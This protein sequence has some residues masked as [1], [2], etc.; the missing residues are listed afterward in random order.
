MQSRSTPRLLA[1]SAVA[2]LSGLLSTSPAVAADSHR[3]DNHAA[4][5]QLDH[6]A[7]WQTDAALRT[8]ME[9][10]RD[11][12]ARAIPQVHAGRFDAA[13]YRAL[14]EGVEGQVGYIVQNCKL[15]PEADEVLHAIIARL[16][17]GVE[18]IGGH[19]A[20]TE[21]EQ[22][23]VHLAQTLDDY[24]AHFDHPGWKGLETGH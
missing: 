15:K 1:F 3:H 21:P 24:A 6:G 18:V 17:Q 22:G 5:L 12:L 16:G 19:A 4:V 11:A 7:R 20:G 8:G 14:A 10:I 2:I 13:Q 23:V 9:A